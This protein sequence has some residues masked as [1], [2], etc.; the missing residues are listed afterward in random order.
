MMFNIAVFDDN[1][2]VLKS[3]TSTINWSE[4]GCVIAGTAENGSDAFNLLNEIKIDI[5]ISDIKMPGIDGLALAQKVS[6]MGLHTK[7]ILITGYHEFELARQAVRLGVFDLLTKP[8][9]ND[10]IRSSVVR[11]MDALHKELSG[12]DEQQPFRAPDNASSLVRHTIAFLNQHYAQDITL[13]IVAAHFQVSPNHL[14]RI[15]KKET[16]SGFVEI[17]TKIR[18]AEAVKLLEKPDAKV[19]MVAEQVGYRDYAY[20]YQVFKKYYNVSPQKYRNKL[21]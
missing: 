14:S 20:F 13:E 9:S 21:L 7:I 11:A 4:L 8:L 17:L 15:M 3:I 5:V 18:L 2:L 6:Q 10:A 16:G 12:T 19:Y 1:P